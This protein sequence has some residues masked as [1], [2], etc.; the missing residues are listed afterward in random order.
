M[1]LS[2]EP[3]AGHCSTALLQAG[4]DQTW[5]YIACGQLAVTD[6]LFAAATTPLATLTLLSASITTQATPSNTSPSS[7]GT[8]SSTS[9]TSFKAYASATAASEPPESS[10][11]NVGAIVGGVIGGLGF[12]LLAG[13]AI[14]FLRLYSKRH[15]KTTP[16]QNPRWIEGPRMIQ[17]NVNNDRGEL[18]GL[19]NIYPS[20]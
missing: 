4:P 5:T 18:A 19:Q 17:Q 10:A 20:S 13:F 8:S 1:F 2:S 16:E 9:S 14:F 7:T 11:N 12:I 15:P 6:H 3:G